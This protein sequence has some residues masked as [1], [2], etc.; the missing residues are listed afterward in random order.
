M[1]GAPCLTQLDQE[2]YL[3]LYKRCTYKIN[4]KIMQQPVHKILQTCY[5]DTLDVSEHT[6]SKQRSS[7]LK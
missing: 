5:F 1:A 2:H 7:I 3:D 6:H 4:M